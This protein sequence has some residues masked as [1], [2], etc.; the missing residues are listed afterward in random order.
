[1]TE[2]EDLTARPRIR[3][4]ALLR[5]GEH[6][7]EGPRPAPAPCPPG[8]TPWPRRSTR[9]RPTGCTWRRRWPRA[10]P[11][12]DLYS[13]PLLTPEAA[14]ELRHALGKPPESG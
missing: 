11:L 6:G 5:F 8:A 10:G 2:P 1:M 12:L 3:D 4:A 13:H 14:A 7:F 9:S